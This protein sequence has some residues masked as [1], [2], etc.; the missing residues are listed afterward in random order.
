MTSLRWATWA[1]SSLALASS[2]C[3]LAWPICFAERV[4]GGLGFLEARDDRLARVVQ[5]DQ[6]GGGKGHVLAMRERGVDSRG[7]GPDP[8]D[9]EHDGQSL[10]VKGCL[11]LGRQAGRQE[12]ADSA[13]CGSA[14]Q[15]TLCRRFRGQLLRR[16]TVRPISPTGC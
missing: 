8:I 6:L 2:F 3:A 12:Q 15:L 1:S 4:A 13:L 14:G 10:E 7:I 16:G 5:R 9:V 11:L